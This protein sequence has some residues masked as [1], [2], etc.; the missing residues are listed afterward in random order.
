MKDENK[1]NLFSRV[2]EE[3]KKIVWPNRQTTFQVTIIVLLIT[4]FVVFMIMLFDL[5]FKIIM[6]NLSNLITRVLK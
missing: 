4:T 6:D 2:V 5:S 3:Y 1:K